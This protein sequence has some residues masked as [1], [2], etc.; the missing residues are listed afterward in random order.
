MMDHLALRYH[1]LSLAAYP[2]V[3]AVVL[4][5]SRAK[6]TARADSDY[7]L[8]VQFSDES[9][10][11]WDEIEAIVAQAVMLPVDVVDMRCAV[12]EIAHAV[13]ASS[14][15]MFWQADWYPALVRLAKAMASLED[16]INDED[17]PKHKQRDSVLSR[18]EYVFE[19]FWKLLQ[20]MEAVEGFSE[21]SPRS[22]ITRAVQLGWI[23]N[24]L[25]W[26]DMLQIRNLLSHT[27]NE[28]LAR[29]VFHDI[30]A[31]FAELKKAYDRVESIALNYIKV[32]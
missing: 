6:G 28:S 22:A 21:K 1:L 20:K 7:D 29:K 24:E 15:I 12:P 32:G 11:R 13:N 27:Y 19:L 25:L 10:K 3:K 18:F 30:T 17:D 2:E 16:I 14:A 26:S 9:S 23:E 4:F 8:A 31:H 5:G